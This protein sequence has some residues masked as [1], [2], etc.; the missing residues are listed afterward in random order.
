M[1]CINIITNIQI[2]N[3]NKN[4]EGYRYYLSKGIIK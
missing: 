3:N 2:L 1:P 4:R